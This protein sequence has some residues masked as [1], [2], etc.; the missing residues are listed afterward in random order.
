MRRWVGLGVIA[1][2]IVQIV[3]ILLCNGPKA[4]VDWLATHRDR[5]VERGIQAGVRGL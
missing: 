3:A 1:D 2:N 4:I 5:A